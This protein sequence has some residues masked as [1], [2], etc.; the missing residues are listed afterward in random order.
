LTP[1]LAGQ[2]AGFPS[3]V[4]SRH[5]RHSCWEATSRIAPNC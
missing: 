4:R 3:C 5:R 1:P 2:R